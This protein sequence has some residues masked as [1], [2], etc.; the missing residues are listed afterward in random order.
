MSWSHSTTRSIGIEDFETSTGWGVDQADS[1]F[2]PDTA[3]RVRTFILW[4]QKEVSKLVDFQ[5][6][7]NGN[8]SVRRDEMKNTTAICAPVILWV[9][10]H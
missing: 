10:A 4:D 2:S 5:E 1:E 8:G 7:L 3:N 6:S 9:C